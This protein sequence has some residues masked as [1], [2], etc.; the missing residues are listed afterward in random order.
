[1]S[2]FL[3]AECLLFST[4]LLV[5]V[6]LS[7]IEGAAILV[8]GAG[9]SEFLGH[10]FHIDTDAD[11]DAGIHGYWVLLAWLHVGRV[12]FLMLLVL[13]LSAFGISG[14]LVQAFARGAMGGFL[15]PWIAA[16]PAFFVTIPVVRVCGFVLLKILPK[17]ESSAISLD[18]L[19]GRVGV[20]V[21]GTARLGMPA[22]ARVRDGHGRSHY[23]MV[24]PDDEKTSFETGTEVLLVKRTGGMKFMAIKNPHMGLIDA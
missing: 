1:M 21:I 2:L 14:L 12:P 11:L 3:S 17:D 18:A 7:V 9:L 6:A 4:A 5:M 13:F 24:E 19:I 15:S 8:S 16:L 10:A 20:I 22:Q 23:V